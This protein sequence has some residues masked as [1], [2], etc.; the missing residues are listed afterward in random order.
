[1]KKERLIIF[2]SRDF[3]QTVKEITR[4]QNKSYGYDGEQSACR[5][6]STN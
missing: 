3:H 2:T 6:Q 5:G 1:M 4:K